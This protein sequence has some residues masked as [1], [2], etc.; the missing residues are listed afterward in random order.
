MGR[1][2]L[3][4]LLDGDDREVCTVVNLDPLDE[5]TRAFKRAAA[6][7]VS[8]ARCNPKIQDLGFNRGS[9]KINWDDPYSADIPAELAD[10]LPEMIE[11]ATSLA[12]TTCTATLYAIHCYVKPILGTIEQDETDE[13]MRRLICGVAN[14][15]VN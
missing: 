6:S 2:S 14:R 4:Q 1:V 12:D 9:V 3:S 11:K 15:F 13:F 7:L 10:R 8:D 5:R